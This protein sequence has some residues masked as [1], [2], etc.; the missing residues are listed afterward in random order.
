MLQKTFHNKTESNHTQVV[1]LPLPKIPQ[2]ANNL[3]SG[4]LD[5]ALSGTR[6][7][8]K[9]NLS[10]SGIQPLNFYSDRSSHMLHLDDG[11][12][13]QQLMRKLNQI[14]ENKNRGVPLE[15]LK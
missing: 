1:R 7:D 10:V 12:E 5:E 9:S 4:E 2:L 3:A 14:Q 15:N 11:N 8:L 6:R 13:M